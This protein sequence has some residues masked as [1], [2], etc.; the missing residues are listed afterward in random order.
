MERLR[1]PKDIRKFLL[2]NA[3]IYI[4]HVISCIQE[5]SGL[6]LI[7]YVYW[8]TIPKKVCQFSNVFCHVHVF[9]MKILKFVSCRLQISLYL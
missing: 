3:F 7:L 9:A 2:S 1:T 8:E 6:V 5:T 4:I